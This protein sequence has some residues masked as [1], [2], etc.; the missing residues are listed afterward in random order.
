MHRW[1]LLCAVL[2]GMTALLMPA[3]HALAAT[4]SA[5]LAVNVEAHDFGVE[6]TTD[7][8]LTASI[9][10]GASCASTI[11]TGAEIDSNG[12]VHLT[13]ASNGATPIT[14]STTYYYKLVDQVGNSQ[15]IDDNGGQ[16]YRV[17]TLPESNGVLSAD[18]VIGAVHYLP[19]CTQ[20]ALGALVTVT[21]TRGSTQSLPLAVT[22]SP[23]G[24]WFIVVGQATDASGNLLHPVA[25][26]ALDISVATDLGDTKTE[27]A[28]YN[29]AAATDGMQQVPDVCLARPSA[30]P[31]GTASPGNT[32]TLTP[33]GTAVPPADVPT[34][35]VTASP[36]STATVTGTPPATSTASP[37]PTATTTVV[38]TLTPTVTPTITPTPLATATLTPSPTATNAATLT[39]TS[40]P[41]ATAGT[42]PHVCTPSAGSTPRLVIRTR[43]TP[44]TLSSGSTEHLLI[45]THP[46]ACL[47][48]QVA[49]ASHSGSYQ[50]RG[51]TGLKGMWRHN[52]VVM[53]PRGY[54][55]VHIT[56]LF[57]GKR[58][59]AYRH[60]TV[61]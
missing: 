6:W 39:V 23:T 2:L 26:D 51:K 52:W 37:V 32:A 36:A 43:L 8:S 15:T 27:T 54:T 34:A 53:G 7:Q 40:T 58:T 5:P 45:V 17:T 29:P 61:R 30:A 4:N 1:A 33:T 38:P 12:Y 42:T 48:V 9:I 35:T 56:A 3:H 10:Y 57:G 24:G 44:K 55:S 20:P 21:V 46:G 50:A 25:G 11:S 47:Q 18:T 41:S 16:C 31:A 22:S 60:L 19:D 14:A 49:Y 59:T 28:P 13:D